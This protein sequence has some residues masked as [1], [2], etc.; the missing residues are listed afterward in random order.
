MPDDGTTVISSLGRFVL[1][2]LDRLPAAEFPKPYSKLC[3]AEHVLLATVSGPPG[4]DICTTR[5]WRFAGA[6]HDFSA[7]ISPR[8]PPHVIRRQSERLL[9]HE[10]DLQSDCH[11]RRNDRPTVGPRLH[12]YF[13]EVQPSPQACTGATVPL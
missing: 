9:V 2:Q 12:A 11:P 13:P 10:P 6:R 8:I 7:A 4:A 5:R 1:S 3:A